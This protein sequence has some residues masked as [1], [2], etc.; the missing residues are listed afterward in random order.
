M[1]VPESHSVIMHCC[2]MGMAFYI[3]C[4]SQ[5]D[6]TTGELRAKTSRGEEVKRRREMESTEENAESGTED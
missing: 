1:L 2:M 6:Q 5:R 3:S 4:L